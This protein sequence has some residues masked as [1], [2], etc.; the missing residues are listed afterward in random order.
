M[1]HWLD[2][3]RDCEVEIVYLTDSNFKDRGRL[4]DF[5]DGWVELRKQP[6][7][8]FLVPTTGIRLIKVLGLPPDESSRLL[9]P[10][11]LPQE[12]QG[13]EEIVGNKRAG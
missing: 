7:E 6:I 8:T 9:R 3:Y 5:G 4:I 12:E 10:A 11:Q 1:A 13:V 2:K